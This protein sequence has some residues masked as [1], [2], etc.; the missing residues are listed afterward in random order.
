MG[1]VSVSKLL[2]GAGGIPDQIGTWRISMREASRTDELRA[3]YDISDLLSSNKKC[4]LVSLSFGRMS[5]TSSNPTALVLCSIGMGRVSGGSFGTSVYSFGAEMSSGALSGPSQ[6]SS[7][8]SMLKLNGTEV[9]VL[10]DVSSR[11]YPSQDC[12]GGVLLVLEPMT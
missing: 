10:Y 5:S 1:V 9:S 11:T 2:S 8:N 4:I 3:Y 12:Y 7:S 6:G